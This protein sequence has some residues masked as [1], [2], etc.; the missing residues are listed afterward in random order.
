M[1]MQRELCWL[2]DGERKDAMEE[3]IIRRYKIR[4]SEGFPFLYSMPNIPLHFHLTTERG[5][6]KANYFAKF[7]I[8]QV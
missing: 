7:H 3:V 4:Q 6:Y 5:A 2:L 1:H 8:C